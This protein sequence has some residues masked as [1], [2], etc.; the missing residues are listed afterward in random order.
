MKVFGEHFFKVS[1]WGISPV[2]LAFIVFLCTAL[3][4]CMKKE[5]LF[6]IEEFCDK[7]KFHKTEEIYSKVDYLSDIYF[8]VCY[9]GNY[10][11]CS[12]F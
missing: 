4:K 1:I 2:F 11:V 10:S 5:V 6:P 7:K 8:F 3:I 12:S 9:F